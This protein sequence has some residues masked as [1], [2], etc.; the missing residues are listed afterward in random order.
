MSNPRPRT[1]D[2]RAAIYV[3]ISKDIRNEAGV[4][5][6]EEE[7]RELAARLG[8]SVVA[9]H[10]DNDREASSGKK[11]PGYDAMLDDVRAGRID[12]VIGWHSDRIYRRPDELEDLI[13]LADEYDVLFSAVVI[14]N[15]DL[16]TASGR[17][18]ARLLGATAKY[19]TE[20]KGERQSS[21][22]K[23]RANDGLPM[24]GGSRPF[25]W[26]AGGMTAHPSE[27][28][29]VRDLVAR[30][31]AGETVGSLT[32][33]LNAQQIP[34]VTGAGWHPTVVKRL[35]MSPRIAGLSTYKGEVLGQAKWD[36][37]VDEESFRRLK[38]MLGARSRK[39]T[40]AGRLALL[41]GLIWCVC[42]YELVTFRQQRGCPPPGIRTY[43]C[44]TRYLPGRTGY[45]KSC[46]RISVKAEAIETDV[47][48]QV[49]ARL[50]QPTSASRL[51][52][53]RG[54]HG[55]AAAAA[56]NELGDAEARLR[57]LGV[58]YAEGLLGRTEFL[59]ARDRLAELIEQMQR[60]AGQPR[61]TLPYG[62]AAAL[63][64]WWSTAALGSQ[65]ALL[66]QTVERVT[67]RPHTGWR[68]GYDT[69]RVTIDWR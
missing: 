31:L 65:Q 32:T 55:D 53:V 59:A 9:V 23:Q 22:L 61:L 52:A 5:R 15:I 50:A 57:S 17:L 24:G 48:E 20:L 34:T 64:A 39:K 19:E 8:W 25:G 58:D 40:D 47:V 11:R 21:Q 37:L 54:D 4:R 69:S 29:V 49:L 13:K 10:S 35:L 26:L 41:P 18:V 3:R 67:V 14:G 6:Q 46:G 43:G 7:C 1:T 62:D 51:A 56:A 66:K 27:A 68:S 30:A 33:W 12:A 45:L 36:A 28:D 63:A 60:A 2:R 42:G 44:R 16:S 38:A